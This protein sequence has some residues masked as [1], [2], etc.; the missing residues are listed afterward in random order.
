MEPFFTKLKRTIKEGILTIRFFGC[1][2][3]FPVV[4]C[5]WKNNDLE[6]VTAKNAVILDFLK[7]E[8]AELLNKYAAASDSDKIDDGP[9]PI[10][11]FWLQGKDQMPELIRMCFESKMLHS[12]N[13]PVILLDQEN[14]QDYV[15]FPEVVWSEVKEGKLKVQHL[16]DMIRVQLIRK[17][18]GVWLDASIYCHKDIPESIFALPIYS[19]KGKHMPQFVSENRWTTFLIG[20][21]RGNVLCSF[22]DDFFLTWVQSGKPFIDYFMFDCAIA[23]AYENIAA[24]RSDIDAIPISEGDCYWLNERLDSRVSEVLLN[25]YRKEP[26]IFYKISW[27]RSFNKNHNNLYHYL[28]SKTD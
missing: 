23:L 10:W 1:R 18:G 8:Y 4:R 13:H 12:G 28:L 24:V 9:A 11:V 15:S 17:Y 3:A 6:S 26:A 27:N 16:A 25:E 14:I 2:V 20:G 5:I 22:L 21:H 7:K 19:L